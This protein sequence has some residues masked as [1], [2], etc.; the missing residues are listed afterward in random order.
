VNA[1]QFLARLLRAIARSA[2][3]VCMTA[4][5]TPP[6][7]AA[8]ALT[9]RCP[10]ILPRLWHRGACALMGL[11]VVRHGQDEAAGAVVQ[12]ANHVSYLD[13]MVIGAL[14]NTIFI[15]KSDVA[16]WPVIGPL[17]RLIG[18]VFISRSRSRAREERNRMRAVLRRHRRFCL[19][20]E[21]TSSDGTVVLPFRSA[22]FDAVQEAG[23]AVQPLS[24][25]WRD[26]DRAY[27]WY[28]EM[29]LLPHLGS[30]LMRDGV[31]VELIRHPAVDSGT[32]A[33]RK[34]LARYAEET[35]RSGLAQPEADALC[36]FPALPLIESVYSH[37]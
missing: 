6:A 7:L 16:G 2:G 17:S 30:L 28:G 29:S 8:V 5:L 9:R 1:V 18:T 14:S 34:A 12:A 19:F 37:A 21:G 20:P 25:V 22:L 33:D 11:R 15:A 3:L 27:A 32:F 24:L 26:P 13:I 36:V 4:V 10:A 35:V 23:A 31:T